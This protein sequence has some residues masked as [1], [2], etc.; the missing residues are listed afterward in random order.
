DHGKSSLASRIL[1]Y[2]GNLGPERQ[3]TAHRMGGA[4]DGV[5][6]DR[7]PD[8][9]A[10]SSADRPAASEAPADRPAGS[11]A[12][13]ATAASPSPSAPPATPDA[14]E[15]ITLLDTL[16]VERE[17]GITVR[18]TAAS[19]LHPSP[20]AVGPRGV[21]LLNMVDT[22]GHVDFGMEVTKS[23]E[24]AE[25][26]VLLFDSARGVQAQTLSVHDKAR[27]VGRERSRRR[28]AC[29]RREKEGGEGRAD[30]DDR[31]GAGAGAEEGMAILPALTK[32]DMPSAR[33]LEV[34]LAASDLMGFDPDEILELGF[35]ASKSP[36]GR[37]KSVGDHL[38]RKG[39]EGAMSQGVD[40]RS[41][42]RSACGKEEGG[43]RCRR[44]GVGW[45][46]LEDSHGD[47]VG[48]SRSWSR[49][50]SLAL[51]YIRAIA[52]DQFRF[53]PDSSERARRRDA[54]S[55][56]GH[57]RGCRLAISRFQT[58]RLN[59]SSSSG[60]IV[61][62]SLAFLSPLNPSKTSA[63]SRIGI[64]QILDS[65][66]ER[67]P[68]PEQ[69]SDDD[70]GQIVR[71]KVIDS[72]FETKRGVIALVR[73]LSGTFQEND[74]ISVVE[75]ATHE[76]MAAGAAHKF[77]KDHYSVQEIGLVAPHRIRTGRLERGQMGYVVAGLR[78]PREARAGSI[79][80]L[81]SQIPTL[82]GEGMSLPP[83]ASSSGN[84]SVLY[85]SV[86]PVEVEG[87]DELHAA[88]SRL[89][90]SDAGLEVQQTAGSASGS[91]GGPFLGPGLRVGFQGLLHAEVFS[92]RLSDEFDLEAVVTPPK[93]PYT[94]RY[95][96][97]K[98]YRRSADSPTEVVIEDLIDW[99]EQGHRFKVLEP[100]VNVRIL[101]PMEYAGSILEL[102]KRKRGT[103]IETRPIDE[104]AWQITS[105]MPWGEVVTDFHDQLKSTSV[106]YA[107]FDVSDGDPP[108]QEA[109]LCKVEI[110]LNG[111]VVDPLSFVCHV[112]ASRAQ[113]RVVCEKLQEVLP[114]QQ[115]V[116]VIQAKAGGKIVAS[117]R[118]RAYRK[119]VLTKA[120]KTMG[121]GDV[122][123]KKKLLEKQKQG[124]K[125]QQSTGKVTLSQAAFRAV[126]SR[127]G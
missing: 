16:A 116:I 117:E 55:C 25:G 13:P 98:H 127:S 31:E 104:L 6:G 68:P 64:K 32:V 119:D 88:V 27:E 125:R 66:C 107:S 21:V 79:L 108:L 80:V 72:W 109:D 24:C 103:K 87:F 84:R 33:P 123:R 96:E 113:G 92:Q 93:V 11:E 38:L 5:D 29:V 57:S 9:G 22:P 90:L 56:R 30:D 99:P 115:F 70:D 14:K 7:I 20:F 91:G 49:A 37:S 18:A 124:K 46:L 86:H 121:G 10:P 75:P 69:L 82:I 2:A 52:F 41:L 61:L 118:I 43:R 40:R 110:V 81:N 4:S 67:V 51:W 65:I 73:C 111:D 19:M 89:A 60:K 54:I 63:R 114:R 76:A 15:E 58:A 97:S 77:G 53:H 12:P 45:R 47:R 48:D 50:N 100:I 34:A 59:I 71:A 112:D 102:I 101:T 1:E 78:D 42:L 8:E 3:R 85:A 35:G 120:G 36:R 106:G 44:Y 126:I 26:C 95:L 23:L 83:S 105:A 28:R 62:I 74:R 122:T 94:I 17:R 39:A